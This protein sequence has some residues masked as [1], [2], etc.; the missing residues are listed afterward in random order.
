MPDIMKDNNP[1]GG[2]DIG[3]TRIWLLMFADDIVFLSNTPVGLQESLGLFYDYCKKMETKCES[4]R[5]TG[6]DM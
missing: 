1:D 5:I 3:N 4:P 2:V 6:I